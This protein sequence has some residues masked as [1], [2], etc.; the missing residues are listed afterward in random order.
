MKTM[1]WLLR[2]ELWEHKGSLVWAPIVTAALMVLLLGGAIIA[3]VLSDKVMQL[4][5][6]G[7]DVVSIR[8]IP[9][10]MQDIVSQAIANGY[11]ASAA[12]LLLVLPIVAFFYCLSAMHDERR[13]RSILFWKSLPISDEQ[14]VLAKALTALLIAPLI[15]IG[16]A[17]IGALVILVILLVVSGA[18]GLNLILPVLSKANLYL[19]PL[20]LLS[21][22]PVYILWALPTVGWLLMVSS[23]ARS[24]VFLWAVGVPLM[25]FG[26]LAWL[27]FLLVRF[28]GAGINVRWFG[29]EV[30]I[31]ILMGLIPGIWFGEIQDVAAHSA[32]TISVTSS[33]I[34]A[35]SYSTLASP[36]LW[37]AA[38]AGCLMIY[39]AMRLRRRRG[40]G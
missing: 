2:R 40:E 9:Y 31:R 27:N 32:D 26:L 11:L 38:A 39:A 23:W 29:E 17:I 8:G 3:G 24:R 12:P 36:L 4:N 33:Q 7:Q 1:K 25:A 35:L 16:L 18:H 5:V 30:I 19:G 20:H 14:T 10:T 21:I 34:A 13:D 37:I 6:N 28:T 15:T 22:L